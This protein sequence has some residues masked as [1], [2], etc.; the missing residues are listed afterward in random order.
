MGVL[1][2]PDSLRTG[3][4]GTRGRKSSE[5]IEM[6]R[7]ENA[8][9]RQD[10]GRDSGRGEGQGTESTHHHVKICILLVHER[11]SQ[12]VSALNGCKSV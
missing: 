4:V 11:K 8:G 2:R 9:S 3:T 10:F 1:Q 7:G 5:F 6:W 12:D